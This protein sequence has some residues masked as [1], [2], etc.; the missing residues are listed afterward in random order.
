MLLS[1]HGAEVCLIS[2]GARLRLDIMIERIS[3]RLSCRRVAVVGTAVVLTFVMTGLSPAQSL[4]VVPV[5]IFLGP[6]QNATTLTIANRGDR[7]T[8]IQIRPYAWS[9]TE[10]DDRLEPTQALAIS[11]PMATIPPGA[12]QLVRL[13]L[14]QSPA[15]REATYRILI[16]QLPPSAE[17]GIVQVVFRL[18]IPIFAEPKVRAL[19]HVAFHVE[20]KDGDVYLVATNNGLRHEAIRDIELS[21]S[22]GS[23]LK[24]NSKASPYVLSG[25][26][27]RWQIAVPVDLSVHDQTLR[28]RARADAGIIDQ[29]VRFAAEP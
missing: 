8:A 11:P 13:I 2:C 24:T 1:A 23:E 22:N 12:T 9:Q 14:R 15:D 10:G 6:Q 28:L 27:R 5:N 16:D 7:Q 17:A 29:Q 18:S 4:A 25:A 21:A 20:R 3:Y 19:A 26:T